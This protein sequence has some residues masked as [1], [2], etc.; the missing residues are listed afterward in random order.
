MHAAIHAHECTGELKHRLQ[1]AQRPM[2]WDSSLQQ[3]ARAR[4]SLRLARRAAR[5]RVAHAGDRAKHRAAEFD[6]C[7]GT[8]IVPAAAAAPATTAAPP[9][10][11]GGGAGRAGPRG[12]AA[13]ATTGGGTGRAGPGGRAAPATTGGGAGRAGPGGFAAPGR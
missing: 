6:V 13:P 7:V 9:A 8:A 4:T 2:G 3:F 5:L 10:A 12:R 11:A 1:P